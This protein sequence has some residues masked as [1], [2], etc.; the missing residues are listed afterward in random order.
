MTQGEAATATALT[1]GTCRPRPRFDYSLADQVRRR[2][3]GRARRS[4]SSRLRP[5]KVE[6]AKGDLQVVTPE[7]L[8]EAE[9]TPSQSK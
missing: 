3:P 6:Q 8:E 7:E 4:S 2:W 5:F 9:E 1:I